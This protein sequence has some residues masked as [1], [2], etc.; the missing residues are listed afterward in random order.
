MNDDDTP[1]TP[2]EQDFEEVERD[3]GKPKSDADQAEHYRL[4]QINKLVRLH[5][6]PP[7]P[8]TVK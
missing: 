8:R 5:L 7:E 6:K 3:F 1:I 4:A 2:D